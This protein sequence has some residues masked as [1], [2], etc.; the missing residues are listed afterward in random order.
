MAIQLPIDHWWEH[1]HSVVDDSFQHGKNFKIGS[2]CVIEPDV[3][4]GDDVVLGDYVKLKSGTHIANNV[5]LADYVKTTGICYIGNDVN[6]RTGS[7]VS[8]SV[9]VEDKV[10]IGAGIM[11]SHTRYIY[12]QRPKMPKVQHITK[13]GFGC[14]IG[15]RTNL[16]AGVTIAPNCVVGYMSNVTKSLLKPNMLY[17]GNPAKEW[18]PIDDKMIIPIPKDYEAYQFPKDKLKK[19]LPY[20]QPK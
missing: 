17:L 8:K 11:S 6:I 9:I 1:H 7:C 14:V 3:V 12:H 4:V 13:L 10:F 5:N 18:K 15:S 16:T 20:Y 19:Y 2:F